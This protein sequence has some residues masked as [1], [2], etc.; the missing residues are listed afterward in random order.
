MS[1]TKHNANAMY[2][3]IHKQQM[4]RANGQMAITDKLKDVKLALAIMNGSS[5]RKQGSNKNS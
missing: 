1:K 2:N 5:Y 4:D 3:M